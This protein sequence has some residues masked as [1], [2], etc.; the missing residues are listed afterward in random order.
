MLFVSSGEFL[1]FATI[2]MRG[3]QNSRLFQ[4]WGQKFMLCALTIWQTR[5]KACMFADSFPA[6][7]NVLPVVLQWLVWK[8]K[9]DRRVWLSLLPV[10]GG[11]MLT[12]VTELSF[13]LAGFLAAFFGCMVTST[14]TILA[15]ALL[16]GYN[17][18][19]YGIKPAT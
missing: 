10:V 19:R 8:K 12:S 18:D 5:E 6:C 9:F 15:E 4:C 1:D 14:K 17:F 11:I 16:H 3:C 13:N 2:V 7:L